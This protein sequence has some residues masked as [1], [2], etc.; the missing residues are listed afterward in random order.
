MSRDDKQWSEIGQ[1]HPNG[2]YMKFCLL[3]VMDMT[4]LTFVMSMPLVETSA[5]TDE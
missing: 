1:W 2:G 5:L 4:Q 3:L